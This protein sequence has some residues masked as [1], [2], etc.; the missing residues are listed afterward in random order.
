MAL[1]RTMPSS[2]AVGGDKVGV[3][4]RAWDSRGALRVAV[5]GVQCSRV[6]ERSVERSATSEGRWPVSKKKK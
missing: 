5:R 1:S 4:S 3:D 6:K 2:V